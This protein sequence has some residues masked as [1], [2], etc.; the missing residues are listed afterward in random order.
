MRPLLLALNVGEVAEVVE[1]VVVAIPLGLG[2]AARAAIQPSVRILNS[3]ENYISITHWDKLLKSR[4]GCL[5]KLLPRESLKPR[6][7]PKG[8]PS[9]NPEAFRLSRGRSFSDNPKAFQ[10]FVRLWFPRGA[11]T[12]LP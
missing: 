2:P 8:L 11:G 12:D 1:D 6:V 10:Q 7:K 4:R 5:E 9:E 3:E